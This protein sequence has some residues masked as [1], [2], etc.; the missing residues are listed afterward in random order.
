MTTA[1]V[2]VGRLARRF[3]LSRSTLL[4]YDSIGLLRPSARS[5]SNYRH[6]SQED[7]ERLAQV[8]RLR[9]AGVPLTDIR[10]ILENRGGGV[11]AVLERRL[12]ELNREI[13][14]LRGQQ[15]VI[16]RLLRR[17]SLRRRVRALNRQQWVALLRAAGLD[18]DGMRAWHREFERLS[19][20]AHQDFLES[21]GIP[22]AEIRRIRAWSRRRGG[23]RAANP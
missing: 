2:T 19:P 21:L 4:Y 10:R 8:C 3:G 6:Y 20:E 11:A 18:E 7:A 17:S 16:V 15:D 13:S 12:V 23:A 22:A 5:R 14:R 1:V 9:S